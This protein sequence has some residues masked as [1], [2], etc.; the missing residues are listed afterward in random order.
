MLE[1]QTACF[2]AGFAQIKADWT[3]HQILLVMLCLTL[4][5]ITT[6]PVQAVSDY[7]DKRVMFV[8]S[9]HQE[10]LWSSGITQGIEEVL[11]GTGIELKIH[12]MD[13][14]RNRS[15]EFI[16]KAAEK[17]KAEIDAFAPDVVIICDD[18]AVKHVLKAF[19]RDA[20]LPFVFC[21]VNW[22][23]SIY[24]LPYG[25][26]TGMVEVDLIKALVRQLRPHS[27]G[28]RIGYLGL[29]SVSGRKNVEWHQRSEN[30]HYDQI[31]M[32][33]NFEQYKDRFNA[34]QDEVD[35]LILGNLAGIDGWN[36][37]QAIAFTRKDIR[38]PIGSLT[39]GRMDF[40]V[41]GYLRQPKEQGQWST[42]A[43]LKILDGIKPSAIPITRNQHADVVINHALSEKLGITFA[44]ALFKR[45]KI[46]WPYEGRR[47]LYI[48][49]YDT[50][51][52]PW[53][54][55]LFDS[56]NSTLD[57]SGVEM[58]SF[59]MGA[60]A[61]RSEQHLREKALEA[62]QLIE[63]FEPDV[64]IT[65]DDAAVKYIVAK[66]YKDSNLPIVFCG[67][68]WDATPYGLSADNV[69]GIIEVG[70]IEPLLKQLKRYARGP[71]LGWLSENSDTMKK[72]LAYHEK[73][74]GVKYDKVYL[75]EDY[76]GWEKAFLALQTEVDMLVLQ[77]PHA[78]R[79]WDYD[80]AVDF[81]LEHT[82]I[83]T[84]STTDNMMSLAVM[85][86]V[87]LPEESGEWV[88][89]T[90]LRILDGENVSEISSTRIENG[91]LMLNTRLVKQLGI[92]IDRAVYK[93]A[94]IVE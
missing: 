87:R 13:T 36:Q 38:I 32:V 34:I 90:A 79:N 89:R 33:E 30:V 93:R 92:M 63:T 4:L 81:A 68:N 50:E 29:E 7:S 74:F 84:G 19:Y 65:A 62:K 72:N 86:Y 22:D 6:T 5:F 8:G 26:T 51:N 73:L 91:K 59:F 70:L 54:K 55:D 46:I 31:Y 67:V 40:S 23:A 88:V 10:Y 18:N 56:I 94:E 16:A 69:T 53:A 58:R 1:K 43:A 77:A 12:R 76:D 44:P 21:G 17:A 83:P 85:G 60:K 82:G 2:C 47:L 37:Q 66:Y 49:S 15:P 20:S 64:V 24:G 71:K 3:N 42:R 14:K 41:L 75:V 27:R 45:A 57:G 80:N 11:Q 28:D 48:S 78:I 25:N 61:N 52:V 39:P 9:Y 35:M